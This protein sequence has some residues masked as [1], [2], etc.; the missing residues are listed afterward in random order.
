MPLVAFFRDHTPFAP[1][2]NRIR[3]AGAAL[4]ADVTAIQASKS[5]ATLL[6]QQVCDVI[7]AGQKLTLAL[8][9]LKPGRESR[10]Q[11]QALCELLGE[12]L[13][14]I[15]AP[16]CELGIVIDAVCLEPQEAWHVRSDILGVGPLY[17]KLPQRTLPHEFWQQLWRLRANRLLRLVYSPLVV[18][19]TCLLP[20]E[21]AGGVIPGLSL[22]APTGSSWVTAEVNV[23]GFSDEFGELDPASFER[24]LEA[25]VLSADEV[26]TRTRWPTAQMRHDAWLNRRLAINITGI[27]TL[28]RRRDVDPGRFATLN[29]MSELLHRVRCVLFAATRELA[30]RD[31]D[32]P[33]LVQAD[34]GRLV[35]SGNIGE[36]WTR[37][38]RQ[39]LTAAAVR[40]RNLLAISPWSIFPPEC[41]DLCYANLLPLLRFADVCPFGPPPDTSGWTLKDFRNFHQQA[42]AV[43]HQRGATH[44]IAV[45]A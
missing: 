29:E 23:S 27:G 39:A 4:S 5:A 25:S 18:S 43:L 34:P 6:G 28:L 38:W 31:G 22:Q 16:F 10:S 44:Q 17:L 14:D 37:L 19:Q 26:H 3:P 8:L 32:L 21:S 40:N 24:M 36:G 20:D 15:N 12:A 13:K 41:A 30:G 42:A 2:W 1:D 35:P 33:A 9:G 7:S 11:F 45:H